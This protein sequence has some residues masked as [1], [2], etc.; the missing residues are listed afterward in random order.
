MI[1][2]AI[3]GIVIIGLC[4]AVWIIANA[5]GGVDVA[6]HVSVHWGRK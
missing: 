2:L 6:G 1:T 3:I 5:G 4:V